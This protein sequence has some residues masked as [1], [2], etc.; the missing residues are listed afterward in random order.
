MTQA[1][2][3]E[4]L[5]RSLLRTKAEQTRHERAFVLSSISS[6]L[7]A[8]RTSAGHSQRSL[9]NCAGMGQSEINRIE[10][11]SGTRAPEIATLVRISRVCGYELAIMATRR[12]AVITA[13]LN[14]P[15]RRAGKVKRKK[16][17]LTES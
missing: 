12:G 13:A 16:A 7:R 5:R 15:P 11:A 14:E 3:F 1:S 17:G 6:L 2:P 4:E 8:L 10:K 9:A